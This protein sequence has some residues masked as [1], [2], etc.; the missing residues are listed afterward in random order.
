MTAE[1]NERSRRECKSPGR[2]K[3]RNRK[4]SR[5]NSRDSSRD[6]QD[7]DRRILRRSN[8]SRNTSRNNSGDRPNDI[9]R[10]GGNDSKQK[11]NRH[12]KY[13]DQDGHTWKYCWEMQANAEKPR[14]LKEMEDPSDTFN[15]MVS[16]DP[17]Y[18]DDLDG[19]IRNFSEMTELN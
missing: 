11:S 6:S 2:P 15:F 8:R 17:I 16:E 1:R 14:R 7:R 13:C 3:F 19:F 18:D 4:R 12:C 9:A 10:N 5:Y